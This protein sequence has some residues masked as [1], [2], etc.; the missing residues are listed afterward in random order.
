MKKKLIFLLLTIFVISGCKTLMDTISSLSGVKIPEITVPEIKINSENADIIN[1]LI[2][3]KIEQTTDLLAEEIAKKL[4]EELDRFKDCYSVA[5]FNYA[6]SFGDNTAPYESEENYKQAETFLYYLAEPDDVGQSPPN[7]EGSNYNYAGE[8]FYVANKFNQAELSFKKAISIYEAANLQDSTYAILTYSN[9]G[10]LY[11]S[12]GRYALAEEYTRKALVLREKNSKDATGTA[13]SFNNLSVLYKDMGRYTDAEDYIKM[14]EEQLIS[15][16]EDK[17]VKYA[18]VLNNKAVIYQMIGKL[19]EAEEILK[20]AISIAG[21][22]L[23]DKSA[24]YVRLKVNLAL[25]YQLKKD[26]TEAEKVY[27]EA[28]DIKKKRLGTN[29]PDYA[30]LLRYKASLYQ[31]MGKFN[32]VEELLNEAISIYEDKFGT[33]NPFYA[34]TVYELGYFYQTQNKIDEAIVQFNQ[35]LTIQKSILDIHNPDLSETYENLAIAYW[36]KGNFT[37]ATENYLKSLDE[38][39]YQ[40]NTF[41]PAMNDNEKTVFWSLIQPK[42]IR[43]YN[44]AIEA[45]KT[46]PKIAEN[47]YNYHIATKALLLNSSRKVKD[48][49]LK[50]GDEDLIEKYNNWQDLKGYIANLYTYSSDEL[51]AEN[52]NLDSLEQEVEYIEKELTKS[53]SIFKDVQSLNSVKYE[54][55][56]KKLTAEEAALEIIRINNFDYLTEDSVPKYIALVLK[57]NSIPSMVVFENGDLM[58][59]TY[60][61]EYQKSIHSGKSMDKYY[62]YY[63]EPLNDLTSEIK[64]LYVSLDGI[65]NQVNINTIMLPSGKYILDEKNVQ[66]VT[67]TKDIL[68]LKSKVTAKTALTKKSALLVGFPDYQLDLDDEYAY[69]APLPGTKVEVDNIQTLLKANSWTVNTLL[70]AEASEDN[71]KKVDNPY[72]FHIATHGYFLEEDVATNA[73]SRAFGIEPKRA[74]ENPLLRSGILLAGADKTVLEMNTTSSEETNDGILNAFEAMILNLEKTEI[75]ILSACQTGLGEIKTGEG[76]YG[77]QRSFQI[78]GAASVLTSLWEVSDDGTQDLMS[79]FYKYWLQSGD[80]YEAFRKAELDI[81]EKYKYPYYWGAFVL[82]GH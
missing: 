68:S 38:Y 7:I 72:V 8:M 80:K 41:Y 47:V 70:G 13:A 58:E 26:Y 32:E 35:A 37:N 50:S 39:I 2:N 16:K 49:I 22:E 27:N 75:V 57:N 10:L 17:T 23:G 21:T 53:S 74:A 28:I 81:K 3:N 24:T 82:V 34:K 48:Q 51:V 20:K 5:D 77:L 76:V 60:S 52:I 11:H 12:T 56:S 71:I 40:I 4:D 43:F 44:Y 25:L 45:N 69:I 1:P 33:N 15:T 55:I 79:A 30:V 46:N 64:T 6:I 18:I 61:A 19:E 9:L 59:T 63:W 36:Q 14:A 78:A 65:Y 54:E 31:Q 73:G 42:L 29:H 62:G 67:N 66:F